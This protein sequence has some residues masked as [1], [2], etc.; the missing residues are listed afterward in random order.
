MQHQDAMHL[1]VT[2]SSTGGRN[3]A[4]SDSSSASLSS[5]LSSISSSCSSSAA[6]SNAN[7]IQKQ[8]YKSSQKTPRAKANGRERERTHLLNE[9]Y[10][11]LQVHIPK[12]PS[13]KMSKINTLKLALD[14]I[15]YLNLLVSSSDEQKTYSPSQ[16]SS[17]IQPNQTQQ[18]IQSY[19]PQQQQQQFNHYNQKAHNNTSYMKGNTFNITSANSQTDNQQIQVKEVLKRAFRDYRFS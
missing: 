10:K 5:L 2:S 7:K 11:R 14:Y 17:N 13:D 4:A 16:C 12:E 6:S 3:C 9:A 15:Q 18:C 8:R 19:S 1:R